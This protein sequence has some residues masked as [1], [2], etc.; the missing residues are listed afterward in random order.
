MAF[1]LGLRIHILPTKWDPSDIRRV[2]AA[3]LVEGGLT[4]SY[5]AE[6]DVVLTKLR[7]VKRVEMCVGREIMVRTICEEILRPSAVI[8]QAVPSLKYDPKR[9]S[10]FPAASVDSPLNE[11]TALL[12]G[13]HRT[14][15]RL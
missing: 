4:V 1:L 10:F 12:L 15:S 13:S 5:P 8:A 14:P 6:A 2:E 9:P 11:L 3:I 7:G